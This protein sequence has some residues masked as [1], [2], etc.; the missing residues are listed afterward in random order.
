MRISV[1]K[2]LRYKIVNSFKPN[3]IG[4]INEN[5][6]EVYVHKDMPEKFFDG[7]VMHEVEERKLVRKGYSY[8][9]SHNEAQ[10]KELAFYAKKFGKKKALRMLKEEER[11]V[12]VILKKM[13]ED[14]IKKVVP[15][16]KK[17]AF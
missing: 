8:E 6:K 2:G 15:L 12:N 1:Y 11:M 4:D 13:C 3:A 16:V 10:K 9:F 7:I 14:G 17:T 5:K